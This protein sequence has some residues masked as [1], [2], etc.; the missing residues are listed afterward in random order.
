MKSLALKI[1]K[2]FYYGWVIVFVS[3][4]AFFFSAPGQ[5][6][7]ISIFINVYET[8]FGYSK[9]A[10]STGYSIAT[11]ISGLLMI[12]I[13]RFTDKFG[14]RVMLVI[15]ATMLA[16][17]TFYNSFSINIWMIFSGFFFLRFFGQGS[18]TLIPNSLVP[19]WFEK[20][21]AVAISLS[22]FGNFFATLLVPIFNVWL[23]HNI[24]WQNAWRFWGFSLLLIFVPVALLLVINR[25]E[26][27]GMTME[28]GASEDEEAAQ[29]SL[30]RMQKTSFT[31][32]QALSTKAFWLAAFIGLI[33]PMFTTGIT[34]H[35]I[36]IM[37]QRSISREAAAI[38]I[39]L[40]ALPFAT[41]PFFAR[42]IIDRYPVQK[43]LFTTLTMYFIAMGWLAF[44]VNGMLGAILFI[45][46]YGLAISIHS[47]TLNTLWPN[48]FGRQ[49]LGSIR[50]ATTVFMVIG[51]ALGPLPFGIVFDQFGSFVP[52]I[53][54]MMV[55]TAL[56]MIFALFIRKPIKPTP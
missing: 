7:S 2:R 27:V 46:F 55:M 8:E 48:F 51:S 50:G 28:N 32:K 52:V 10:L 21:R 42:M 25:P 47:V 39:G 12:F 6:Y 4:L 37:A 17:T 43:V 15:V 44:F 34:F 5:T 16:F 31:L 56:A 19:Q 49:Y 30:E 22:E 20:K 53:L 54:G 26:N 1:N 14:Q 40:I 33:A 29:K 18:M 24:S 13:G 35:W 9:T 41:A 38:T 23:I 36:A 45:L 3:A 11:T